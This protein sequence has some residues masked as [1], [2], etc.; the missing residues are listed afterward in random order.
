[1]ASHA[2]ILHLGPEAWAASHALEGSLYKVS[3]LIVRADSLST[4]LARLL[5]HPCIQYP[6][7]K[8]T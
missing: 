5:A 6:A 2:A 8:K 3:Y 4:K 7:Y 1:M